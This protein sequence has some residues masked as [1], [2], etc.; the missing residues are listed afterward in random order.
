MAG[1]GD[2]APSYTLT[3]QEK[4]MHLLCFVLDG[5]IIMQ[6]IIIFLYVNIL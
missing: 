2:M 4:I 5:S 6:T 1:Y 3:K